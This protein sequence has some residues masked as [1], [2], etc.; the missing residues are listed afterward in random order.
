MTTEELLA[1]F[2]KDGEYIEFERIDNPPCR[3][4]D[5]CAFLRLQELTPGDGPIV[6]AAEHDEIFLAVN[7][8]ELAAV[9]TEADIIYLQRCGVRVD[10]WENGLA[11]FA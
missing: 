2:E 7:L 1:L 3:R 4:R 6:S 10:E 11:M 8:D 9:A 5:I